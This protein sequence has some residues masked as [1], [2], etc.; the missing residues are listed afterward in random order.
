MPL[1]QRK[2]VIFQ[3]KNKEKWL[4]ARAALKEA[5]I[6]GIQAGAFEENPVCGCGAKLDPRDFGPKGK[7]DR[8]TY[9]IRVYAED[10]E[11]AKNI[12]EEIV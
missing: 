7:I 2:T 1:F 3:E 10:A 12:L 5:G 8:N 11:Q 9:Y 4:K 6:G